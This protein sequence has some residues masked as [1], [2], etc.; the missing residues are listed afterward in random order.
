MA[1]MDEEGT[2]QRVR[3]LLEA[4]E[5]HGGKVSIAAL[6]EL[7]AVTDAHWT[8]DRAADPPIVYV[9]P[10]RDPVFDTLSPR[11]LDVAALVACGLSNREI[12]DALFIS[13]ATTKDHVHAILVKTGL[14]GRA[15]IIAAWLGRGPLEP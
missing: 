4:I 8:I 12:A 6:T 1:T 13:V 5:Q 2:R 11:E 3:E 9:R 10:A 7:A 14:G 15:G